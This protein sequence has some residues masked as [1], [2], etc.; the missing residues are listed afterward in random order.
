MRDSKADT[1][2]LYLREDV[3]LH[4]PAERALRTAFALK[5]ETYRDV[6]G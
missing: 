4:F 3:V 2:Q 5:G 6:P 1:Q